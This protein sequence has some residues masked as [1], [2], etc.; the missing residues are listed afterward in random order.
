MAPATDTPPEKP[1]YVYIVECR[2]GSLYTGITNDIA[3]RIEQH[4]EGTASRYTRSR[5]PVVLRHAEPAGD[6]SQALIREC[7]V[8]LMNQREKRALFQ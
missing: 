4:N 7:A 3:R 5:R 2:D 8:K 6:R 1:W